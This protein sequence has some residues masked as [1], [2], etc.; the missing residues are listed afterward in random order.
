MVSKMKQLGFPDPSGFG[1]GDELITVDWDLH[2]HGV[3]KDLLRNR[4]ALEIGEDKDVYYRFGRN[5]GGGYIRFE[6]AGRVSPEDR[7]LIRERV[8]R[9]P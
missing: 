1:I 3:I 5:A 7:S 2:E 6:E 8:F 9:E 4:F